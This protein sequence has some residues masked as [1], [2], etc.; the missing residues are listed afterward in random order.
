MKKS[1]TVPTAAAVLLLICSLISAQT[2]QTELKG[3][4]FVKG[5]Q[6]AVIQIECTKPIT[7]ESFSLLNP[8]RLVLDLSKIEIISAPILKEINDFGILK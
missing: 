3:I 7:Y 4:N 8:N 5:D 6:D 2:T 1:L